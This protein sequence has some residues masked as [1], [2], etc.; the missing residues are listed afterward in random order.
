[1]K[2]RFVKKCKCDV[3][4]EEKVNVVPMTYGYQIEVTVVCPECKKEFRELTGKG[5]MVSNIGKA[6]VKTVEPPE[7]VTT[8]PRIDP[9]NE[10]S[11]DTSEMN[12][13]EKMAKIRAAKKKAKEI[14]GVVFDKDRD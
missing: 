8:P 14:P 10:A 7:Q 13:G 5:R 2:A 9:E 6:P 11:P 4:G 12:F 1:M 3:K